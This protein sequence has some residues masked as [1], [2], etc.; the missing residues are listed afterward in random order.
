LRELLS[1]YHVLRQT[2]VT[3]PSTVHTDASGYALG[4]IMMIILAQ[5]DDNN[6][7]YVCHYASRLLK[8]AGI[9]Y[10]ISEK[11]CLAIVYAI[12]QFRIYLHGVYFIVVTDHNAL[13]WLMSVRDPTGKLARW[14][15]FLQ[16]YDYTIIHRQGRKHSNVDIPIR[17]IYLGSSS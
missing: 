6:Q 7:E 9:H 13:V 2:Y 3:R 10:G 1:T 11:D 4:A 5:H 14:S 17:L 12:R 8:N 16:H 15:I